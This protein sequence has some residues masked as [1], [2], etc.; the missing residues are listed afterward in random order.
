MR[1]L[2]NEQVAKGVFIFMQVNV[3]RPST[4][5]VESVFYCVALSKRFYTEINRILG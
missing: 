3:S 5:A 4:K 2:F 1:K